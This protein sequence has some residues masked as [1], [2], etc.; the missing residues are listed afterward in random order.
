MG[1]VANQQVAAILH[2]VETSYVSSHGFVA[3]YQ[4]VEHFG[5]D[6]HVE[7]LLDGLAI[8]FGQSDCLDGAGSQPLGELVVPI[9]DQGAGTYD[10]DSLGCWGRLGRNARL[11]EGVDQTY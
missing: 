3:G 7:I 6:E 10:D 8:G 9:L 5:L 4:N 1:L 2:P 11:E